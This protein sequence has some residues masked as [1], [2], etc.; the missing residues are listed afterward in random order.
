MNLDYNDEDRSEKIKALLGKIPSSL[1]IW[2]FGVLGII[3]IGIVLTICLVPFPGG[4][5]ETILK[6]LLDLC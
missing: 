2:A 3:A 6:H 5:G 4:C 1:L